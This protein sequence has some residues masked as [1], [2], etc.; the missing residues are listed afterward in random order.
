MSY[1]SP[2]I[3]LRQSLSLNLGLSWVWLGWKPV[4][5]SSVP[6]SRI[7]Q[8]LGDKSVLDVQIVT[9]ALR[10]ELQSSSFHSVIAGFNVNLLHA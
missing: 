4:S 3:S 5:S 10:S 8:G 2:L 6:V 7:L 9:W 1:H